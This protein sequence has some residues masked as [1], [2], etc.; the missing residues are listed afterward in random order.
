MYQQAVQAAQCHQPTTVGVG[1]GGSGSQTPGN[2]GP[3]FLPLFMN[4]Q[5]NPSMQYLSVPHPA[6]M[7]AGNAMT[8]AM[9]MTTQPSNLPGA[10]LGPVERAVLTQVL[11]DSRPHKRKIQLRCETCSVSFN[12]QGQADTHYRG[13]RHARIT[14][15]RRRKSQKQMSE[16]KEELAVDSGNSSE[17]NS[18]LATG[19]SELE[20]TLNE[21]DSK[22]VEINIDG[23]SSSQEGAPGTSSEA[24][25]RPNTLDST[26]QK[27]CNAERNGEQV[28]ISNLDDKIELREETEEEKQARLEMEAEVKKM[29]ENLPPYVKRVVRAVKPLDE[30]MHCKECDVW[31]NSETQM[32]QHLGSLR[33]KNTIAGIPV[34]PRPDK[35]E[36]VKPRSNHQY[37]CELCNV[38]L[39]S[40]VQLLQHLR[41]QRHKATL[42]GKP[43]KPRWVPYERFREQQRIQAKL[44]IQAAAYANASY[45]PV[46]FP[47]MT[48]MAQM[49]QMTAAGAMGQMPG[50]QFVQLM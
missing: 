30:N 1:D 27:F 24:D 2:G 15:I 44:K 42:E 39:N 33:H 50:M 14:E 20:K 9:M 18:A 37:K 40:E 46:I 6:A 47:Q 13:K 31:V 7:H 21:T 26:I 34:P 3:V 12:S 11:G 25:I 38:T 45:Q 22:T 8:N 35:V 36:P 41:S 23:Q 32:K 19:A 43:P 28:V 29:L 48:Q 4:P 16:Q 10:K 49:P 17:E 5:T